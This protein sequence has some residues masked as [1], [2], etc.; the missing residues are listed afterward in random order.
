L[1]AGDETVKKK[2]SDIIIGRRFREDLGDIDGLARSINEVNMIQPVVVDENNELKA[3]LRRIKAAEQLGWPKVPVVMVP[4]TDDRKIEIHENQ[5]RKD[6][7]AS[8]MVAIKRYLEPQVKA[9]AE[10]RMKAG[11]P[12]SDSDKGRTDD[13][14][15]GFVGVGRDKLRKAEAMVEAAEEEPEKYAKILQ[16]V[17][18]GRKSIDRGFRNIRRKKTQEKL[19]ENACQSLRDSYEKGELSLNK[20]LMISTLLKDD[21]PPVILKVI[22]ESP[23]DELTK[24]LVT[25]ILEKPEKT[26]EILAMP[27]NRLTP[28]PQDI[29][30]FEIEHGPEQPKYEEGTCPRCGTT[31]VINWVLQR[32]NWRVE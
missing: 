31:I 17:N 30:D 8:E 24:R 32:Y 14:I 3:G 18:E 21:Q 9:G 12:S 25:A 16:D 19:L 10:E 5:F 1:I 29:N 28:P 7:T 22:E 4:A 11:T 20:S 26:D 23:N 15:A 2:L 27:V 13:V 6:Y